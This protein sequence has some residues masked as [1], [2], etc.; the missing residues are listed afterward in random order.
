MPNQLNFST[1]ISNQVP[2]RPQRLNVADSEKIVSGQKQ[3]VF[4]TTNKDLVELWVYNPDD[5]FAGHINIFA[6]DSALTLTTVLDTSG[7]FEM[8]NMDLV[9]VFN[10]LSLPAGRY[11]IV[12]NFFRDEVGSEDGY[13]LFVS[14]VSDDRTLVKLQLAEVNETTLKELYEFVVPSVPRVFA[15]AIIDQIFDKAINVPADKKISTMMILAKITLLYPDTLSRL[16]VSNSLT[17]FNGLVT[18]IIEGTYIKALDAL[19]DDIG[20]YYIQRDELLKYVT[21]ALTETIDELTRAEIIDPR[22]SI[23]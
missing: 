19:I 17:E 2:S 14:E 6:S 20:N 9:E 8:L 7:S 11:S 10:R 23:I 21:D 5:T 3:V 4:G 12:S 16:S 15:Q 18:Q 22:F 1:P 13:K